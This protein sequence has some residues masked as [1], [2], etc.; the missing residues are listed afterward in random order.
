MSGYKSAILSYYDNMRI[1]L[2]ADMLHPFQD[3]YGYKRKNG[4]LKQDAE[5]ASKVEKNPLSFSGCRFIAQR[6]RGN[7]G[8]WLSYVCVVLLII[9]LESYRSM[10][11]RFVIF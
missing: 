7:G 1:N 6:F 9:S 2:S 5:M 4:E 3:F 11:I 8:R 10:C